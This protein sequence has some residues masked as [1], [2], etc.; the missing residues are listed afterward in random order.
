M[1]G[2]KYGLLWVCKF[3]ITFNDKSTIISDMRR[4]TFFFFFGR[5]LNELI[6]FYYV[7]LCHY[8]SKSC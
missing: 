8:V 4:P 6:N 1:I 5:N 2:N 7:E 3:M